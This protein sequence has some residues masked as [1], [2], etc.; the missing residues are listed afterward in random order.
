M[1]LGMQHLVDGSGTACLQIMRAGQVIPSTV[2]YL[3][4]LSLLRQT[5]VK[6]RTA[7]NN[8]QLG[9]LMK[10]YD[11]AVVPKKLHQA[12]ADVVVLTQVLPLITGHSI[13][14]AY[15]MSAFDNSVLGA[16]CQVRCMGLC[17]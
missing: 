15:A 6:S 10:H 13:H 1:D 3:D 4:T 11:L 14:A 7:G 16:A 12:R 9:T 8:L 17:R 2:Y 5:D